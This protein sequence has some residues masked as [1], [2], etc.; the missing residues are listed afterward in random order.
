MEDPARSIQVFLKDF[1]QLLIILGQEDLN[2]L[3]RRKSGILRQIVRIFFI[4]RV[5]LDGFENNPERGSSSA[6]ATLYFSPLSYLSAD[7]S[8]PL[9]LVSGPFTPPL[10][11]KMLLKFIKNKPDKNIEGKSGGRKGGQKEIK[12]LT[13]AFVKP[14]HSA[15]KTFLARNAKKSLEKEDYYGTK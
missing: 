11:V 9:V 8:I 13:H 15:I 4:K 12:E 6:R 10:T 5:H 2:G 1:S 14:F 7:I 3:I